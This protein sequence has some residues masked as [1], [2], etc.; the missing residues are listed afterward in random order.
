MIAASATAAT[1]S[2]GRPDSRAIAVASRAMTRPLPHLARPPSGDRCPAWI[3]VS[4]AARSPVLVG[5]VVMTGAADV[6]RLML[7]ECHARLAAAPQALS[8]HELHQMADSIPNRTR[9]VSSTAARR[10]GIRTNIW[11]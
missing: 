10:L 4:D 9:I 7:R 2:G 11:Q 6:S 5:Q 8:L 3:T 1:L